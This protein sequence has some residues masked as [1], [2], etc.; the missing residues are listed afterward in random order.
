MAARVSD[1]AIG[2]GPV[3]AGL[4][5][6]IPITSTTYTGLQVGRGTVPSYTDGLDEVWVDD[7]KAMELARAYGLSSAG[8][9]LHPEDHRNP[10]PRRG[11]TWG[12]PFSNGHSYGVAVGHIYR[13][14]S[15]ERVDVLFWNPCKKTP[16][17]GECRRKW[18]GGAL[19]RAAAAYL[20]ED[21]GWDCRQWGAFQGPGECGPQLGPPAP[22][23]HPDFVG[24]EGYF[25][26]E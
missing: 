10:N 2:G 21:P 8:Q 5:E 7:A 1:K 18:V 4:V 25:P 16:L 17:S 23:Q 13:T 6:K 20:D 12:W 22:G 15:I 9:L 14:H 19:P 3:Y 11:R 26:N 24:E